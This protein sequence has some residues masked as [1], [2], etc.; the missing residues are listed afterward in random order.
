MTR[1]IKFLNDKIAINVLDKDL[2]NAIEV[3]KAVEGQ[4]FIKAI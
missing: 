1:G 3:T 4:S 2:E